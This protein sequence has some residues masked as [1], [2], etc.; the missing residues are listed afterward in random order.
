MQVNQL[1][2]INEVITSTLPPN[3]EFKPNRGFYSEIG[4]N[5]H[6]FAKILRGEIEPDRKELHAIS[7]YFNIPSHK[8]I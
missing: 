4:I 1:S 6:R 5:K 7:V 2:S 8:L 3:I